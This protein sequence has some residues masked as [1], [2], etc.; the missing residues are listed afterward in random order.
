[1]ASAARTKRSTGSAR[2]VVS[3]AMPSAVSVTALTAL[4]AT[5]AGSR[6]ERRFVV[7]RTTS[8]SDEA[9]HGKHDADASAQERDPPEHAAARQQRDRAED[10]G[11]FEE[12]LCRVE[13][14]GAP[15]GRLRVAFQFFS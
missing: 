14:R 3:R 10:D 15:G 12:D 13:H 6:P 4:N 1:M 11:D 8:V 5:I 7:L 9:E 2:R